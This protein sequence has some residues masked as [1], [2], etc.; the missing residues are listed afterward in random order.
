MSTPLKNEYLTLVDKYL[1][2]EASPEETLL[3]ERYYSLF[4]SEEDVTEKFT[5]EQLKKLENRIRLRITAGITEPVTRTVPMYR[6]AWIQG[7]AAI[8][9]CLAGLMLFK[10][11]TKKTPG[12]TAVLSA[13]KA[14]PANLNHYMTLADGSSV[15]LRAGSKITVAADFKTAGKREITLV[16]EAYFDIKHNPGRPFIIHTGSIKTTVLGTAFNIKANPGQHQ[17]IVTVTR[18]RVK[19]QDGDVLLAIL[20]PNKQLATM[21]GTL[22]TA[23]RPKNAVKQVDV[24]STLSWAQADMS[25]D[26]VPFG[27]LAERL[28][29][30]Y[31]VEIVFNNP[32]LASCPITGKFNGT[33]TLKDVLDVITQTRNTTYSINNNNKVMI[34]GKGCNIP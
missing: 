1:N 8:L 9:I 6:N 29:Q 11:T 2:G 28:S 25:F 15:V 24:K 33:E 3:L 31:G 34:D 30:R 7:V 14:I 23:E 20:T 21:L 13:H 32:A 12:E 18:G 27:D 19:V 22:G 16:G 10:F 26:A 5:P 4:D 17:V